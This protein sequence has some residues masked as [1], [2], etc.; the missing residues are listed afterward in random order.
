MAKSTSV[1]YGDSGSSYARSGD[2]ILV[3][4]K[5][6]DRL[7]EGAVQAAHQTYGTEAGTDSFRGLHIG[8]GDVACMLAREPGAPT[9]WTGQEP[10]ALSPE[11]SAAEGSTL[12]WLKQAFGL[13]GFELDV[14]L[15]A[16]A[17]EIDLRYERLYAYL[18]DDV[19]RRRPTV[20]LA[21]NLCCPSAEARLARRTNFAP[22]APLIRNRL[23]HLH[24]DP[25]Q[26]QSPLLAHYLKVDE[27]IVRILLGE[28]GQD[29]RLTS[30]CQLIEP[31]QAS[32]NQSPLMG[33]MVQ[34]LPT[35]V[36]QMWGT[37]RPLRLYFHGPRG[38]GKRR[39]AEVLAGRVEA[40]L[41]IADLVRAVADTPDFNGFLKLLFRE[42]W[43]RNAL[44]YLDGLDAL[45]RGE[46]AI[47][48]YRSLLEALAD[49]PGVTILSSLTPWVACAGEPTGVGCV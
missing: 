25:N 6:L 35:L 15:I 47:P 42:A 48:L 46:Q 41:L 2:E 3:A 24:A 26:V 12:S 37:R 45:T 38:V 11:S 10:G 23:L 4:L 32:L 31:V 7:L 44:L 9:L 29:R 27:Q 33:E 18:Q 36:A 22:D 8:A 49:D 43:F 28:P 14:L 21:L 16:L 34:A 5:R 17:P 19:T 13:S 30:F 39:A 1:E 40:P 20:D